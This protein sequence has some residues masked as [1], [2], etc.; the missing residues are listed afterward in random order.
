MLSAHACAVRRESAHAHAPRTGLLQD[1]SR[2]SL[3]CTSL[4]PAVHTRVRCAHRR[5]TWCAPQVGGARLCPCVRVSVSV[6]RVRVCACADGPVSLKTRFARLD[7]GFSPPVEE[8]NFEK[9]CNLFHSN[10]TPD[11][12]A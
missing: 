3:V 4:A 7:G 10:E 8:C 2:A 11:G 5:R 6:C 1:G 9:E 12:V